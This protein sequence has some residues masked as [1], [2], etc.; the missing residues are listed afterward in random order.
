M[1]KI[2]TLMVIIVMLFT[3][4]SFATS[5]TEEDEVYI[6]S[7]D[8]YM[9]MI[10]VQDEQAMYKEYYL[11]YLAEQIKSY[12][13]TK[14]DET[15]KARVIEVK[16]TEEYY[17]YDDYGLYKIKYQPITIEILEGEQKEK[18]HEVSYILTIDPYENIDV[19]PIKENQIVNVIL[20]EE[21]G[22][23]YPYITTVDSSISRVKNTI[24]LLAVTILLMFA[25]LGTKAFKMLPQ[26]LLLSDILILIFVPELLAGRSIIWL[27]LITAILYLITDTVIKVGI[28]SKTVVSLIT[29]FAVILVTTIG[30]NIFN[31]ISTI[32]GITYEITPMIEVFPK[33][34]IDFYNLNMA[35]YILIALITVSDI[36]NKVINIY[37][38]S[39][40]KETR[41]HI[42]EYVSSKILTT[43]GIL[44]ITAIPN[45][46]YVLISKYTFVEMINSEILTNEVVK[47]LFL[48]ISMLITT[49]VAILAKKF[50]VK[51]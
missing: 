9:N 20:Q 29:T 28:N 14:R 31:S 23:I 5:Q 47:I 21:Q 18:K 32:S 43:S 8:E 26:L 19:K 22:A 13:E 30:L 16:N 10:N 27:T 24:I 41:L 17:S 33:G 2:L 50:L 38:K 4:I 39:A 48:I 11:E 51:Q 15:V 7:Y 6:E 34:T 35:A 45:Y 44:L 12:D 49:E 25:F 37:D 46:L 42:K 3:N 40:E 36:A 1:K